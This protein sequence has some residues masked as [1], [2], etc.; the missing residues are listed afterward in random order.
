MAKA[1][2]AGPA[3]SL[4]LYETLIESTAGVVR[5]GT[6]MPYTARSGHM[7]SFLDAEGELALR[8]PADQATKFRATYDSGVV[9]Q[10]G[11]V[12]KDYVAVPP[13]LLAD[14]DSLQPWLEA[15]Y[16]WIG[17]LK[18]KPTKK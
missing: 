10:H 13:S 12:L 14:T 17:N 5:K 11:R 15:S 1:T 3:E 7:F 2:Y 4:E 18:P 16:D 9:E 6:R 8:L